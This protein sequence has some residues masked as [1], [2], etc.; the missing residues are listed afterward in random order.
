[1]T[2]SAPLLAARRKALAAVAALAAAGGIAALGAPGTAHASPC[3]SLGDCV[4]TEVSI[5]AIPPTCYCPW[6][7]YD[8]AIRDD[9]VSPWVAAGL[10]P[11]PLPP[12]YH[13]AVG[14][15]GG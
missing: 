1:M 11:Q 12:R 14:A 8:D 9:Y 4:A 13:V 3:L 2:Y 6:E 15:I 5:E 7:R 10:N